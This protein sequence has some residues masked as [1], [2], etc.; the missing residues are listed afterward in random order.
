MEGV[1]LGLRH[2]HAAEGSKVL[3]L[4]R[5]LPAVGSMIYSIPPVER[6]VTG[7][8]HMSPHTQGF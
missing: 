6:V 7:E 4:G 3:R 1:Q 5:C 8:N 2:Y